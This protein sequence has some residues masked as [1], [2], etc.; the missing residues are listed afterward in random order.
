MKFSGEISGKILENLTWDSAPDAAENLRKLKIIF[1][2]IGNCLLGCFTSDK[3][4]NTCLETFHP[5][6]Q[7]LKIGS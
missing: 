3:L 2:S 7:V 1:F 5:I 4:K 6:F